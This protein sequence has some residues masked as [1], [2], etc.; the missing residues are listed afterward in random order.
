MIIFLQTI[1][2]KEQCQEFVALNKNK[3]HNLPIGRVLNGIK[4]LMR[5][6][7][8]TRPDVFKNLVESLANNELITKR[9]EEQ[10]KQTIERFKKLQ[11]RKKLNIS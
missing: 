11:K 5:Q 4:R 8:F 1:T 7:K 10:E 6:Y 3:R 9:L 2:K